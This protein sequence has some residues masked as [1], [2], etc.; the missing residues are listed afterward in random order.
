MTNLGFRDGTAHANPA[1]PQAPPLAWGGGQ[2]KRK[3]NGVDGSWML[4]VMSSC[5]IS[6]FKTQNLAANLKYTLWFISRTAG[7]VKEGSA[8]GIEKT[9][10]AVLG[11]GWS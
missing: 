2:R 4:M 5:W 11:I 9:L 3:I 10:L 6:P 1:M 7:T 8:S